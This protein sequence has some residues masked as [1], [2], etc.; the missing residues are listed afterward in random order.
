MASTTSPAN[1]ASFDVGS[2][3]NKAAR[4][5][6]ETRILEQIPKRHVGVG[7]T[8]NHRPTEANDAAIRLKRFRERG[9][10]RNRHHFGV[11][12]QPLEFIKR[13]R[14]GRENVDQIIP[15][16]RQYPFGVGEAFYAD[17]IFATSFQLLADFFHDGLDLLGIASAADDEKIGERGDFAQVQNANIEGLLRFGGSNGGE[18]RGGGERRCNRMRGRVV[19]LSDS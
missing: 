10:F 13:P 3:I 19:L 12:P 18:P 11:P 17:G 14:F 16:I 15:V 2:V 5:G 8:R 1:G 6:G 4:A 7:N 9:I